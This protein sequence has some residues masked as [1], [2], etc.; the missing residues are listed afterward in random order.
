MGKDE[1]TVN[2]SDIRAVS[3]NY[4]ITKIHPGKF[5][6]G[7][8]FGTKI[9]LGRSFEQDLDGKIRIYEDRVKGWFL[10]HAKALAQ[11]QNADFI[12]LMI[13]TSYLEGSQQ[14]KEGKSSN[15]DSGQMIKKALKF[16]FHIPKEND[17][18]LDKFVSEVRNGLFHDCMTRNFVSLNRASTIRYR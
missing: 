6:R 7:T 15:R 3:P 16:I 17:L 2:V 12:V 5:V 1:L 8:F 10:D 13:C 14:F 11:N 18:I 9:S 4:Y